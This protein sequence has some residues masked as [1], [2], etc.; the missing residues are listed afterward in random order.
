MG[1]PPL[2]EGCRSSTRATAAVLS[3][4]TNK[5]NGVVVW[6]DLLSVVAGRAEKSS[7]PLS[8]RSRS[9]ASSSTVV[10][11]WIAKSALSP[12]MSIWFKKVVGVMSL[13][14]L[15][16]WLWLLGFS[17]LANGD[18]VTEAPDGVAGGD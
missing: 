16:C 18:I 3:L 12:G 9:S 2:N 8:Q 5:L 10:G 11:I 1:S 6:F 7:V 17:S 15:L 4:S 14:L 13:V